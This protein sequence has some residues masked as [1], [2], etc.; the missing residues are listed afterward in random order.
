L[1]AE[2]DLQ[3]ICIKKKRKEKK[4]SFVKLL[5]RTKVANLAVTQM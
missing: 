5:M 4:F 2:Q 1:Q 3:V